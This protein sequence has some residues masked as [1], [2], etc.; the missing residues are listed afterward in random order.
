MET[1]MPLKSGFT[2]RLGLHGWQRLELPLLCVLV[3]RGSMLLVGGHGSGKT[4]L[5]RSLGAALGL[6]CRVYD[7]TKAPF[8]D[9]LGYLD[10]ASLCEGTARYVD[11]PLS[12]RGAGLILVDEIS[13]ADPGMQSKFLEIVFERTLMGEPLTELRYVLAAMNP[14][15]YLGAGPV[16]EAL[17]GRFDVIVEVPSF[18][19][20]AEPDQAAAVAAGA[21][22]QPDERHNV[23]TLPELVELIEVA[24][25]LLPEVTARFGEHARSYAV[26]FARASHA[27]RL[28]LDGRRVVMLVRT[29]LAAHALVEAGWAW[30]GDDEELY[31]S[32]ALASLPYVASE[33]DFDPVRVLSPHATAW[34]TAGAPGERREGVLEILGDGDSDRALRRYLQLADRLDVL[35]HDRVVHRF[36][37]ELRRAP[38]KARTGPALRLLELLRAV[39]RRHRDFPAELVVRLLSFGRRLLGLDKDRDDLL[40]RLAST[41]GVALD[42]DDPRDA[43]AA[44]LALQLAVP[45]IEGPEDEPRLPQA[46]HHLLVL[47]ATLSD[48]LS[49]GGAPCPA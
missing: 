30:E 48:L 24:R 40:A 26:A 12:A 21:G 22:M 3:R 45:H 39:Q 25:A 17:L 47:R 43:L 14:S 13:R 33:I 11:T 32:V 15:S 36:Q 44:R 18:S 7:A 10:P 4:M 20:L 28:P 19:E 1:P 8:E 2:T 31:R 27:E 42:L 41:A 35:E 9:I 34:G 6:T 16:D 29:L 46:A 23:G 49:G 5:A 37:E 38:V